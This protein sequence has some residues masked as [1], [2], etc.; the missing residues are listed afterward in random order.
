MTVQFDA[1]PAD[2]DL[3]AAIAERA[4]A[5]QLAHSGHCDETRDVIMDITAAHRNGNPLDLER[6]L[7]ADDF[8]L[9]HDVFGISR[10]IDRNTGRLMQHFRPRFSRQEAHA[11]DRADAPPPIRI[12]A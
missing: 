1:S 8:N 10:H 5:L 9:A 6:L 4:I 3:I 11:F 2:Q 12:D 7:A